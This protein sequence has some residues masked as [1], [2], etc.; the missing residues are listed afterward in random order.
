MAKKKLSEVLKDLFGADLD[1]EIEIS[2]PTVDENKENKE[3]VDNKEEKVDDTSKKEEVKTSETDETL[4][5]KEEIIKIFE[6]GWY[7][8]TSGVINFDKIKNNEV[9]EAVKMLNGAYVAEKENRLIQ[10]SLNEAIKGCSLTVSADTFKKV[11]DTSGVKID[12]DGQVVGI[13]EAISKLRE[14]E[15]GFFVDKTKVS[16]SINEGFNPVEKPTTLTD[17]ELVE[18]AYGTE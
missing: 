11:L 1:K 14:S 10:D 12:K 15:P 7:D 6:D 9:L 5:T 16:N 3:L 2:E 18:L 8:A 17:D 4:E 13:T